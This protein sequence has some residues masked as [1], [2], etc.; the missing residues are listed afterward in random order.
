LETVKAGGSAGAT[1][2]GLMIIVGI[3]T[4]GVKKG[5]MVLELI[6]LEEDMR[7]VGL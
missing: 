3:G 5:R 7:N 6:R 2:K 4:M 1:G